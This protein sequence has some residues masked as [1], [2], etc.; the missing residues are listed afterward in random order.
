M[1][2]LESHKMVKHKAKVR[3]LNSDKVFFF[4]APK[5]RQKGD[6]QATEKQKGGD[7]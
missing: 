6:R 2:I 4:L 7:R 3:D 5:K 1:D